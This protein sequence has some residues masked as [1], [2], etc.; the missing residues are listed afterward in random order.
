MQNL[1][2]LGQKTINGIIDAV[3][4]FPIL[5]KED[6]YF[7]Q[8]KSTHL[9]AVLEKTHIW[10]TDIQKASIINDHH[11]PTDHS[12]FHQ[13]MLEQKVQFD[14]A[15]Y[16]A[17]DFELKRLDVEEKELEISELSDSARDQIKRKRFEIELQFMQ[18]ELKQ[19]QIAMQYRMSEIKG[20]QKIQEELL[21]R[22]RDSGMDED[23]IWS[24]NEGELKS[25]FFSALN[26]LQALPSTVDS[27]ER[28]NLI[29][30]AVF[31]YQNV[32]RAGLLEQFKKECTPFQLDS[33]GWLIKNVK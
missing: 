1:P 9:A 23:S 13:A 12:K 2:V 7:L 4:S 15:M 8:E 26:N 22:L 17:K 27:G 33:L 19:M 16:L 14:Q 6:V 31:S 24:K 29:S 28:S 30:I 10:R 3:G 25:M 20:W 11:F 21:T 18:Y 5:K 32:L